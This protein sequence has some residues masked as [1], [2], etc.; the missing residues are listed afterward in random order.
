MASPAGIGRGA[1]GDRHRRAV[2]PCTGEGCRR[3]LAGVPTTSEALRASPTADR[4][5]AE[6]LIAVLRRVAPR[7]RLRH[8]VDDLAEAGVGVVEITFD[9][10]GAAADLAACR[11]ARPD[12]LVGAGTVRTTD[13]LAAAA[14]AG[15]AFIVSPLFDETVVAATL[16]AG[17][18]VL[19]GA[20]TPT[21]ADRAWRAGATFVKLFPASSLGPAHVRELLGPLAEIELVPT[22][23]IDA[24]NAAAYLE[25]G[26]VA[27]GVGSALVRASPAERLAIVAAVRG[28]AGAPRPGRPGR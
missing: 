24:T 14:A 9:G 7:D 15:A 22:G 12:L 13:Q 20:A 3:T 5:R 26:A 11:A 10:D 8:L 6:R 19:P 21:E 4:I 2:R 17:L 23:G 28:A 25:A 27:V 1:V 16:E 18:P